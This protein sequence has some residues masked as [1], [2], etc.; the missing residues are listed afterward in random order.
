MFEGKEKTNLVSTS[1][2]A[3]RFGAYTKLSAVFGF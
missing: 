3:Q 1:D 2:F